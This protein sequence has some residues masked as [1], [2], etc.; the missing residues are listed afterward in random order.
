[1]ISFF[2]SP[3]AGSLSSFLET[4]AVR[5]VLEIELALLSGLPVAWGGWARGRFLE[6]AV[7]R[8][9]A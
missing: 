2:V 6:R 1:M 8:D 9:G 7:A 3:A 5:G 4:L